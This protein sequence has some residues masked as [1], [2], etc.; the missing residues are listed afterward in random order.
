MLQLLIPLGQVQM[1]PIF[2][3]NWVHWPHLTRFN[4]QTTHKGG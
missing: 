1:T 3:S 2:F 4:V